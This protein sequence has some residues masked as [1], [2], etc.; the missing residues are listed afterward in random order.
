MKILGYKIV[1]L[2]FPCAIDP[3]K[4][5]C[6]VQRMEGFAGRLELRVKLHIDFKA[7]DSQP[8]PGSKQ[9]LMAQALHND[10]GNDGAFDI[11]PYI[12]QSNYSAQSEESKEANTSA[13]GEKGNDLFP[14]DKFHLKLPSN[15]DKYS[16]VPL[17][18]DDE[19][20]P[21]DKFHMQDASSAYMLSQ[22][23]DA[24][25]EKWDRYEKYVLLLSHDNTSLLLNIYVYILYIMWM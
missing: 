17:D 8:D 16:G 11:N 18:G 5:S 19:V 22:R 9:W 10:I 13:S 3:V 2:Y 7:F 20:L 21:E 4:V 14:E 25:K 24:V 12:D 1:K 6:V 15:V 23:K